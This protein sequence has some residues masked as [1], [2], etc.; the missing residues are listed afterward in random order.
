MDWYSS[1]RVNAARSLFVVKV[2][3]IAGVTRE[4]QDP[5]FNIPL[6]HPKDDLFVITPRFDAGLF[7]CLCQSTEAIDDWFFIGIGP[8][9]QCYSLVCLASKLAYFTWILFFH[10]VFRRPLADR[11]RNHVE[12]PAVEAKLNESLAGKSF[13]RLVFHEDPDAYSFFR[14]HC[15][16]NP[17]ARSSAGERS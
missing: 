3:L 7:Q 17:C 9:K 12:F 8:N 2:V 11:I 5:G 1:V 15:Y 13:Q 6:G 14:G 16:F 10:A 4:M